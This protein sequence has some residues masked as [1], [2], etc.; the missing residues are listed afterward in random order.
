MIGGPSTRSVE[1]RVNGPRKLVIAVIFV[2][3]AAAVS[4]ASDIYIAQVAAGGNNGVDC[5]DAYAMTFF[6]TASD[7]GSKAGQIGPGTTVHLC[8][9]L[10]GNVGQTLLTFQGSGVSGSPI[11]LKF[12][13]GADLTSPAWSSSGAIVINGKNYITIDGGTN[14]TIENTANGTNLTYNQQTVGI[15][16]TNASSVTIQN[17]T[18]QNLCQRTAG[19]TGDSC[20]TGGNDSIGISLNGPATNAT[21]T[22]NTLSEAGH[23]CIFYSGSS[24]DAGIVISNNTISGCNWGIGGSGAS[25]GVTVTGND[26]TCVAGAVCNW[27][28]PADDNHHNGLFFFPPNGSSMNNVVIANNYFHDVNGNTT[29]YVFLATSGSTGNIPNVLVYN[30]VFFTT[31]G[32]NGPANGMI[33]IGP[34]ITSPGIYNNTFS[35]PGA[36]G[37]SADTSSIAKNNVAVGQGYVS[38]FDSGANGSNVWSYNDY[39]SWTNGWNDGGS[40]YA[41]LPLW[42]GGTGKQCAG[43]CDMTGSITTNP[44]LTANFTLGTGSAALGSGTNLISLGIP[45]LNQGAPQYFGVNY[46]CGI[47][48]AARP[49]SGAWDMGAYQTSS[50]GQPAPPTGL[51]ATVH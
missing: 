42:Q 50:G 14:G 3:F 43:G 32:Q 4:G 9:T 26:I 12:E 47:G 33:T 49:S 2:I 11:T 19:D 20:S 38:Y 17:L 13:S 46:A 24:S 37:W 44:N 21:V 23:N 16:V 6:N 28:D 15:S 10:T 51:T 30:N 29:A 18:L 48:C 8:G 35:G 45:G 41:T 31:S 40:I 7:W 34:S 1:E 36:R 5:A 22:M 25:N 39:F 27:D